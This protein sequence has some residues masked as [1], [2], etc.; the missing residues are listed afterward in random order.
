MEEAPPASVVLSET[1]SMDGLRRQ[2]VDLDMD[3]DGDAEIINWYDSSG[4]L[5]RRDVDLN[6]D[7]DAS[8]NRFDVFSFYDATGYIYREEFDGDF[9]GRVDWIDHYRSGV[10]VEAEADTNYDGAMDL[11]ISYREGAQP[12]E[13]NPY[14]VQKTARDTNGDGTPDYLVEYPVGMTLQEE[15]ERLHRVGKVRDIDADGRLDFY[16]FVDSSGVVTDRAC[17]Q[18]K[19]LNVCEGGAPPDVSATP[20]LEEL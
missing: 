11:V 20:A 6:G 4:Q 15:G 9:D 16:E 2:P 18:A 3:A 13:Y 12:T 10:R 19:G 7:G 14:R 17:E 5:V 8:G 1:M